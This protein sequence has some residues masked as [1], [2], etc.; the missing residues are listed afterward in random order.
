MTF[1]L[2]AFIAAAFYVL[3]R[4]DVA[5]RLT[6]DG[7]FYA[8][9]GTGTAVPRPYAFRWL[10]PML[11]GAESWR[12][13]ALSAASLIAWGPLMAWY[14]AAFGLAPWQQL[15]GVA[16]LCGLPGLFRLNASFPALVDAP[17]FALA[18]AAAGCWLHGHVWAGVG[19]AVAAGACKET[20]PVF[21]A[22]F[23]WHPALLVGL[24]GAAW[25][26]KSG[27]APAWAAQW[28]SNPV[29]AALKAHEGAWLS[30]Q[31]MLLPWG[32][33][34]LLAPLAAMAAPWALLIPAAVAVALGYAQMVAA[35]DRARL[36]CWAAPAVIVVALAALP[37]E[38]AGVA[39]V[40]H[41][42]NP[43]RGA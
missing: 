7:R 38:W 36:F 2:S 6:P 34:A 28:L 29:K 19:L 24:A 3:A 41:A 35:Q 42:F 26:A 43:Y 17:A 5:T 23:A 10:P 15:A 11:C 32:A 25:W 9:A 20:A 31:A 18:L 21:A 22:V 39:V 16:L 33:L 13:Q 40:A 1:I 8:A 12:W 27:P 37:M 14:L 30:W 4:L